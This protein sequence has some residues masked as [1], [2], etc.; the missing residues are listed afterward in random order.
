M[1]PVR[2]INDIYDEPREL[3]KFKFYFDTKNKTK[4]KYSIESHKLMYS[5]ILA[6][7]MNN[8]SIED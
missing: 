1:C 7:S 4:Q 2:V 6:N 3:M 5:W 8:C